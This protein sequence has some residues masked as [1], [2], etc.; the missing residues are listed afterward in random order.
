MRERYILWAKINEAHHSILR[1]AKSNTMLSFNEDGL[2][3]FCLKTSEQSL[4]L[5]LSFLDLNEH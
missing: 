2:G 3:E 5:S 1:A 4:L